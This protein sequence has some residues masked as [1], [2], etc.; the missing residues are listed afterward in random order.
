MYAAKIRLI[1]DKLLLINIFVQSLID[2]TSPLEQLKHFSCAISVGLSVSVLT[3]LQFHHQ[4]L[5]YS[6]SCTSE[7]EMNI[8]SQLVVYS[9]LDPQTAVVINWE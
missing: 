8:T 3:Q 7:S 2:T 4:I 1:F 6:A 5:F 9:N